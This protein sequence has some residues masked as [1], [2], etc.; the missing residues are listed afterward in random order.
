MKTIY[1]EEEVRSHPHTQRILSR[2]SDATVIE[3]KRY[4]EVFNR[5]AQNF[6]AQKKHQALILAQKYSG[7]VL[8]IPEG[9]EIGGKYNYY[10]SHILN[11]LYDCRYCFLQGMY[12]SAFLVL[13]INYEAFQDEIDRI[14][15][16][17]SPEKTYFFSGYDGDSLVF[18]PVTQF[19]TTFLDFFETRSN[20]IL[21]LRTKSTQINSLLARDP[22]PNC[23]IAFSVTP[24]K[25]QRA[26][27]KG[28]PTIPRRLKAMQKLQQQGW[29]IGLR[30]D[31]LIFT[32]HYKEQYSELFDQVFNILDGNKLHSVTMGPFRL[33][34][35]NFRIL[36]SLYPEEPFF[37]TGLV[38]DKK[39]VSY[40]QEI[41]LENA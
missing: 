29:K 39:Q 9:L 30:F 13:F 1:I 33:P 37:M 17:H 8:P 25:I 2:Y 34:K 16:L 5:K 11:C 23:V 14:T 20:A 19:A 27:E 32:P 7:H 36:S 24:E 31:P 28:T 12:R 38:K 18:E 21:E 6:R 15:D 3:C 22:I 40:S 35:E 4:G 10:F 26:L 41:E